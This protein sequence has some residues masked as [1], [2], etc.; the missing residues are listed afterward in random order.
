MTAAA[1]VMKAV[2]VLLVACVF[3]YR[4]V[5]VDAQDLPTHE[6][7]NP[8]GGDEEA[9]EAD[10]ANLLKKRARRESSR[11]TVGYDP[12]PWS[13]ALIA[14]IEASS[15]AIPALRVVYVTM[16]CLLARVF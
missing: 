2:A 13:T 3:V 16:L 11:N 6:E 10:V 5:V 9:L 4:T 14:W 7:P 15:N 1:G 8:I 12:G